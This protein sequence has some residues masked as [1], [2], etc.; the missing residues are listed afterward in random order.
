MVERRTVRRLIPIRRPRLRRRKADDS[1]F[2]AIGLLI[3]QHYRGRLGAN[4]WALSALALGTA[5]FQAVH[6]LER[7]GV[8][9]HGSFDPRVVAVICVFGGR[10][11]GSM[12][13]PP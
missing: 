11:R 7:L 9:T 1:R 3:Y 6:K 10:L 13:G 12:A 5:V 4:L 8:H 2:F